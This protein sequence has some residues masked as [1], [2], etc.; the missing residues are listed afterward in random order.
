MAVHDWVSLM[1]GGAGFGLAAWRRI[2]ILVSSH[3][4]GSGNMTRTGPSEF[5]GHGGLTQPPPHDPSK[6]AGEALR[7]YHHYAGAH[8][9]S[10]ATDVDEAVL[11]DQQA[12]GYS[13]EASL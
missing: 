10:M 4:E 13:G 11:A 2:E 8:S 6:D 3:Q 5:G 9:E 1:L 12:N 7:N